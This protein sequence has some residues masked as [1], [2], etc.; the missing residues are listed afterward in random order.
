MEHSEILS[1]IFDPKTVTLLKCLL[2]KKDIFYL[3]DMA[4]ESG[5]S[6]ATVHRIVQKLKA[7][8]LVS[9]KQTG[10]MAYYALEKSSPAFQELS[11]ILSGEKKDAA[12]LLKEGLAAFGEVEVYF[13]GNGKEKKAIV[14]GEVNPMLLKEL[15][16]K[17]CEET[18]EKLAYLATTKEQYAQMKLLGLIK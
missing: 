14:V 3:R 6:L 11:T 1:S 12:A 18:G 2:T 15:I 8:G 7:V 5:V 10:K 13:T 4:K 9:K 17:I 16:D